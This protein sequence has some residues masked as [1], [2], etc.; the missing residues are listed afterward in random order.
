MQWK[1]LSDEKSLV[2]IYNTF[3]TRSPVL[4]LA[5]RPTLDGL[6]N[7]AC[8]RYPTLRTWQ[9]ALT[10]DSQASSSAAPFGIAS[11]IVDVAQKRGPSAKPAFLK[12]R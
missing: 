7:K 1:G 10:M 5:D 4:S 11:P 8:A 9:N 6:M 12:V 3:C 2:H